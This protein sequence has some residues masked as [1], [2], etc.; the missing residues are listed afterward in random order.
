M[1]QHK[2]IYLFLLLYLLTTGCAMDALKK[3][4]SFIPTSYTTMDDLF[5][6]EPPF[7]YQVPFE[8]Y[9][10]RPIIFKLNNT[11]DDKYELD[12]FIYTKP[13]VSSKSKHLD[14]V[15]T[16]WQTRVNQESNS[17]IQVK[18]KG[19]VKI[20]GTNAYELIYIA[21]G[22]DDRRD[23]KSSYIERVYFIPVA[24]KQVAAIRLVRDVKDDNQTTDFWGDWTRFLKSIH[25]GTPSI[26]STSSIGKTPNTRHYFVRNMNFDIPL[27]DE[28]TLNK[29]SIKLNAERTDTWNTK[30]GKIRVIYKIADG[31]DDTQKSQNEAFKERAEGWGSAGATILAALASG[32]SDSDTEFE[33]HEVPFGLDDTIY[34]YSAIQD[35]TT[36]MTFNVSY[37]HGKSIEIGLYGDNKTIEEN[38]EFIFEWLSQFHVIK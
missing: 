14:D 33:Y 20:A 4:P 17:L 23:K 22:Y 7:S 6:P 32:S 26:Q 8:D 31:Y 11:E 36:N 38:K 29:W 19:P 35:E 27:G 34:G 2:H 37:K 18:K 13:N 12:T 5:I 28:R 16:M 21:V 9:K 24:D 1:Q 3:E 30:T 25:I 10:F 15:A